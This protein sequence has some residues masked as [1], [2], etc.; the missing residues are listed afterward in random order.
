MT[1]GILACGQE[2]VAANIADIGKTGDALR[3]PKGPRPKGLAETAA[4]FV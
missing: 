4:W 2:P 3:K 1:L